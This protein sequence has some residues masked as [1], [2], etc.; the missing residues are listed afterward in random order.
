MRR[1]ALGGFVPKRV[2]QR[3]P[4]PLETLPVTDGPAFAEFAG[5]GKPVAVS[6]TMAFTRCCATML[7]DPTIGRQQVVP[8]IPDEAR[9]FGMDGA[10]PRVKIYAAQGQKYEPVDSNMLL[11]ATPNRSRRTDPR[12]GH[13]RGG[14]DGESFTAQARRIPPRGMPMMPFYIFYSMF[15]FQRVGD[16]IWQA[17]D[18][19]RH[20]A[21]CSAPPPVAPR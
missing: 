6:T 18:C 12:R 13:H 2:S 4:S 14:R 10:V 19:P 15:G 20:A 11:S 17:A 5:S 7:R 9:T 21:S 3:P 1:R 8:I 16:L